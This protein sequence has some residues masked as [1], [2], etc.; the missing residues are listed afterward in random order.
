MMFRCPFGDCCDHVPLEEVLAK[1][2]IR[3]SCEPSMVIKLSN[4]VNDPVMD[5]ELGESDC[6]S[7]G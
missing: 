5:R 1:E 3:P 7:R 4:K 6:T 2:R